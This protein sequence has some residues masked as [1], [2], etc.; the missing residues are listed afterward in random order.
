MKLITIM[1]ILV[2]IMMTLITID[3]KYYDI[4]HNDIDD[5]NSNINNIKVDNMGEPPRQHQPCWT[6]NNQPNT[7]DNN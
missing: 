7:G 4:D 5:N 1:M 6:T 2:T 3:D